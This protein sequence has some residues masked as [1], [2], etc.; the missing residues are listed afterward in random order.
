MRRAKK[1][2]SLHAMSCGKVRDSLYNSRKLLRYIYSALRYFCCRQS[3]SDFIRHRVLPPAL[4]EEC[5]ARFATK[6][7]EKGGKTRLGCEPGVVFCIVMKSGT[8]PIDRAIATRNSNIRGRRYRSET[9]KSTIFASYYIK[10][11]K[12]HFFEIRSPS[13]RV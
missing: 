5:V 9:S 1:G 3:A 10:R 12:C 7:R 6:Y 11:Q 4:G 13:P 2:P 8:S